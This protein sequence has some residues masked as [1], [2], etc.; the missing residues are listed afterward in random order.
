MSC[1]KNEFAAQGL[2]TNWKAPQKISRSIASVKPTDKEVVHIIQYQDP[3]QIL[4]YCKLNTTKVK[5]C[6]NIHAN[7]V[8]NKY[9]KD[10]GPFKSVELEHLKQQFSYQ[11]V[12][13]KLQAILKDV[14]MKTS[15]KVKKLVT[16]R[17]NFCQKNSK[18]FL[19]KCLT[20]YLEKDTFTV[21][22]Q[23]HGKHK[24]NGH[25]YL[26]LKKEINK[27]LK[28]KLL[29]AKAFIKKQQAI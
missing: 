25:E 12:D 9:K 24:M 13:Q 26:F 10:Y 19:E 3:K 28:K 22:N 14:E 16:A 21:L 11:D 7:Q 29:K 18:Y 20:Q 15:K 8:L 23:F 4:I 1:E 17:K 27:Q 5:A 2:F 6:Y